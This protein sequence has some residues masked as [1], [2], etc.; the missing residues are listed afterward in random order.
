MLSAANWFLLSG[1]ATYVNYRVV[2][3]CTLINIT[4]TL[5]DG[6]I[7]AGCRVLRK[8]CVKAK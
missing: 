8:A 5:N 6:K 7:R 4:T 3:L 2:P 1:C